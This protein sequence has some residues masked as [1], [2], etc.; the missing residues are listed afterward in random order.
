MQV[1]HIL[2]HADL[3]QS[4]KE[5]ANQSLKAFIRFLMAKSMTTIKAVFSQLRPSHFNH[6]RSI[7]QKMQRFMKA[8]KELYDHMDKMSRELC[9]DIEKMGAERRA[10]IH[11]LIAQQDAFKGAAVRCITLSSLAIWCATMSVAYCMKKK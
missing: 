5:A 4:R 10:K 1:L 3:S 7:S 9:D 8:E 2:L 6:S 11:A